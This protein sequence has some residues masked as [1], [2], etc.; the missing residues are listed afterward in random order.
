MLQEDD[1]E[2]L[3]VAAGTTKSFATAPASAVPELV[4]PAATSPATS[5]AC[6]AAV[7]SVG[8]A[9]ASTGGY[10]SPSVMQTNVPS[11]ASAT[12]PEV[13]STPA[14][15]APKEA[16]GQTSK[17]AAAASSSDFPSSESPADGQDRPGGMQKMLN[18][19][20]PMGKVNNGVTAAKSLWSWGFSKVVEGATKIGDDLSHLDIAK[21][22]EKLAEKTEQ[23]LSKG[24]A[25]AARLTEAGISKT[26]RTVADIHEDLKPMLGETAVQAQVAKEKAAEIAEVMKP[27]L[28]E[29][30]ETAKTSFLGAVTNAAKTA[31]WFQSL[32]AHDDTDSEVEDYEEGEAKDTGPRD[33]VPQQQK[34]A[35]APATRMMEE[36]PETSLP[37]AAAA[38][39]PA[40]APLA[41]A[42]TADSTKAV[43]PAVTPLPMATTQLATATA[44]PAAQVAPTSPAVVAT[45]GGYSAAAAPLAEQGASPKAEQAD[46]TAGT[47]AATTVPPTAA[48]PADAGTAVT[49]QE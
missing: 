45:G 26:K 30:T 46:V 31:I 25:E 3:A 44:A 48:P 6:A 19:A 34:Q 36:G 49:S 29:A 16:A 5:A 40:A 39:S 21:E 9:A 35:M 22:T 10:P 14:P 17:S 13:S 47:A 7:A 18:E 38:V 27:K 37:A 15:I 42:A 43:T 4:V 2:V 33:A 8:E 20:F 41:A 1:T 12:V 11:V 23:V 28:Q 24:S 32:G